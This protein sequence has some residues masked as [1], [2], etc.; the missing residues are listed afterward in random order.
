M[1]RT[2][3]GENRIIRTYKSHKAA[4]LYKVQPFSG[5]NIPKKFLYIQTNKDVFGRG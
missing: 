5:E 3:R 2:S 1:I 4:R